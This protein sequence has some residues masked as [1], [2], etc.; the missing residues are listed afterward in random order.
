M[1]T[2]FREY[3]DLKSTIIG[4]A[5]FNISYTICI[6][7]GKYQTGI[8]MYLVMEKMSWMVVLA[9]P[10]ICSAFEAFLFYCGKKL[11]YWKWSEILKLK[12][13]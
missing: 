9:S 1:L 7:F 2:D 6:F 12:N 13:E 8:W 5:I 3:P 4:K 11:N 10:F